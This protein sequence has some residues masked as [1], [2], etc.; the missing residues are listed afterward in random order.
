MISGAL[1]NSGG[2][3]AGFDIGNI[4]LND[5]VIGLSLF[6]P[7]MDDSSRGT[8]KGESTIKGD[9]PVRFGLEVERAQFFRA[10]TSPSLSK[11][12]SSLL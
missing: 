12:H 9:L 8:L 6:G 7:V 10:R 1:L 3:R 11:L 5:L 2:I 4:T